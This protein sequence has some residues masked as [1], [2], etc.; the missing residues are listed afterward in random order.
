MRITVCLNDTAL[1]GK[2]LLA[3]DA[4]VVVS[5]VCIL[6]TAHLTFTNSFPTICYRSSV[7]PKVLSLRLRV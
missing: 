1:L 6:G 2:C 7:V 5:S 4:G 3:G